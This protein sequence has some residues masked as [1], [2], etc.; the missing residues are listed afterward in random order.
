MEGYD[1]TVEEIGRA[2]GS[3]VLGVQVDRGQTT[4]VVDRGSIR[5]ACRTLRDGTE[6]YLHLSGVLG[7]DYL[8]MGLEPR[9]AVVYH[10]YSPSARRRIALKVP[11]EEDDPVVPSVVEVFPA[12]DWHERETFDMFGI[13]FEGHPNLIRILMPEDADFHPLRKDVPLGG[14]EVQF[15]HT[16]ELPHTPRRPK[17]SG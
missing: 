9:F 14:E 15:G 7:A 10:L 16:R 8:G 6:R 13:R 5:E 3:G 4:V 17:G 11:L 1:A 2:L 12:A